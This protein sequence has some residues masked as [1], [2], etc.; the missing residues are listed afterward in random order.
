MT[1]AEER[2]NES[3][4][5]PLTFDSKPAAF[6]AQLVRDSSF[7]LVA[8]KC[9]ESDGAFDKLLSVQ[10]GPDSEKEEGLERSSSSTEEAK[11]LDPISVITGEEHERSVF[12]SPSA[13]VKFFDARANKWAQKGVGPIHVNIRQEEGAVKGRIG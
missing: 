7:A 11:L 2:S 5:T 10:K 1:I 13:V 12:K 3:I 4:R 8:E 6:G 9:K